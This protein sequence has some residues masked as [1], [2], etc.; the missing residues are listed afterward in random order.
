V[1]PPRKTFQPQS[2]KSLLNTRNRNF[3]FVL[4]SDLIASREDQQFAFPSEKKKVF[5]DK[6]RN[7]ELMD[8]QQPQTPHNFIKHD[9]KQTRTPRYSIPDEM[10]LV[11]NRPPQNVRDKLKQLNGSPRVREKSLIIDKFSKYMMEN[12]NTEERDP[13]KLNEAFPQLIDGF[14]GNLSSSNEFERKLLQH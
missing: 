3:V 6:Y 10:L 8:G 4:G 5:Q 11:L 1:S 7:N 9:V 13:E 2:A 14:C 12:V